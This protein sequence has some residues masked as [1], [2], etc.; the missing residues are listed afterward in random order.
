MKKKSNQLRGAVARSNKR[1]RKRTRSR[2]AH[3]AAKFTD[4]QKAAIIEAA[5]FAYAEPKP[6]PD[7]LEE[8]RILDELSERRAYEDGWRIGPDGYLIPPP[9][10]EFAPDGSMIRTSNKNS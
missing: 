7:S 1:P 10:W 6:E 9:G 2:H 4:E 8:S 3:P 5:R